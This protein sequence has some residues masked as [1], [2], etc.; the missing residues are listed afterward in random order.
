[1]ISKYIGVLSFFSNLLSSSHTRVYCF[2]FD[3]RIG[4]ADAVALLVKFSDAAAKSAHA[5]MT[6]MT[7]VDEEEKEK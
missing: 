7:R 6:H 1:M 3:R 4:N 5:G 2:Y